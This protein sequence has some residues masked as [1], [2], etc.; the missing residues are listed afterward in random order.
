[1]LSLWREQKTRLT[2]QKQYWEASEQRTG[3]RWHCLLDEQALDETA[4]RFLPHLPYS[5]WQIK[6]GVSNGN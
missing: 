3:F 5:A 1:M 4:V 6:S 2:K